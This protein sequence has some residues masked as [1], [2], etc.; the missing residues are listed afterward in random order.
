MPVTPAAPYGDRV[1]QLLPPPPPAS[2][3]DLEALYTQP[4][5]VRLGLAT[6]LDGSTSVDGRSAG[7]SGEADKRVFRALR[8]AADVV[9]VGAGTARA[10]GYRPARL[11]PAVQQRRTANGQHALPW[12]AVVSRGA[13]LP[14]D[15]PLTGW[16]QLRVLECP[17][18]DALAAAVA[19]LRA[20]GLER[21]LC[22]GGPQLAGA[23]LRLGLVDEV[24]AT[25]SPALVGGDGPRL[26]TG[27]DEA[28]RPLEL[29]S[30]LEQ[31]GALLG[32]W[33]RRAGDR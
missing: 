22:E 23:L 32:R 28:V 20:D 21:V 4:P 5:G 24:C 14:E 3:P 31:D 13:G 19:A 9:L 18:D 10:E 2:E 27:A 33:V 7:L 6:S 29:V 26:T 25:V 11:D 15:S 8:A 1:R 17:D 16:D 30:L 12:I